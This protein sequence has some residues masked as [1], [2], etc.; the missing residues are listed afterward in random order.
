M[1]KLNDT[2]N[3][4]TYTLFFSSSA[5]DGTFDSACPGGD[6][7]EACG[8]YSFDG[9]VMSRS[10]SADFRLVCDRKSMLPVINSSYMAGVRE[11]T[12]L[13]MY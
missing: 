5:H 12:V 3:C 2:S 6:F 10:V 13:V 1:N 7:L 4:C 11:E 8:N 9:S